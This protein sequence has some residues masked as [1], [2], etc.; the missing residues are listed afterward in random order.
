MCNILFDYSI[1]S[2]YALF[3]I[4]GLVTTARGTVLAYCEARRGDSD[5]AE[6]DIL[7]RR[8][9]DGGRVFSAP[10]VLASGTAMNK[11]VN[12][13]VMI[14]G[15]DGT[16]HFL[17]C[18]E[19]GV[20]ARDGGVFYRRSADDGVTWS[21]PR[22]ISAMTAPELRNVF[23][24]GPGHGIAL[25]DGRLFV[26]CWTVLKRHGQPADSHHP[27]TVCALTSSDGGDTWRI[28]SV[29]PNGAATDPNETAAAQLPDGTVVLNIRDGDT[30]SRCYSVSAD[31][32]CFSPIAALPELQDPICCAGMIETG[33]RLY[34]THC[35]NRLLRRNLTLAQSADG[36][37]WQKVQVVDP[38]DA[39]YSDLTVD[40]NKLLILYEKGKNLLM[41]ELTVS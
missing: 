26:P 33:G 6:I 30:H 24:T 27:G 19:Y 14:A 2:G 39:G 36:V 13:P 1:I 21:E 40:D 29:V 3:R 32:N 41:E 16:A 8:S 9:T 22:N 18:V 7:L 38:G 28:A 35:R 37:H 34:L 31:G 17:Y 5:W 11:T 23:A 20:E 25:A 4:P 10:V 12:N 15:R